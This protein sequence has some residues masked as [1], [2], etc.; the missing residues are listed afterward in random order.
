M[1]GN[2]LIDCFSEEDILA[3][4]KILMERR[5]RSGNVFD[6]PQ[7]VKDYLRFSIGAEE[8][9]H[10]KVLFLDAQHRLIE[11]VVMFSGT[12]SQTSVYPRE[13]VKKA[14]ELNAAAVILSHNHPSGSCEPSRAD[15]FLT[16]S[17]KAAL[18]LI[19]VRILDHLVVSATNTVSFAER[20]LL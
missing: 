12:L 17:L 20:G 5:V 8:R 6:S 7:A 19:D 11:G 15:E 14:L 13:V 18:Q 16:N 4:A 3:A 1:R 9:E 10:F 2:L